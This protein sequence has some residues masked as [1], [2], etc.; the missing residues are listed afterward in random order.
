MKNKLN[1]ALRAVP[2]YVWV[3]LFTVIPLFMIVFYAFF[4]YQEGGGYEF[5]MEFIQKS[6]TNSDYIHSFLISVKYAAVSTVV[7]L[8]VGYPVA[9]FLNQINEKIRDF[10]M[11][12]FLLPMWMNFII[13]TYAMRSLME[14]NG[15]LGFL[16]NFLGIKG[17]SLI[18]TEAA[19]IIGMV[20]NFLPFMILPIYTSLTKMDKGLIEAA[21]DLGAGKIKVFTKVL[22][23][24]TMPGIVSGITMV[25]MPSVTT[26]VIPQMLNNKVMTI[27][28]I[29]EYKFKQEASSTAVSGVGAALSMVLMIIVIISMTFVNRFSDAEEI[30]EE[31]EKRRVN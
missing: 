10:I 12:L 2:L 21:Q 29:I 22:L 19:I 5:T 1:K 24:L 18:G 8:V 25:F 6:I 23:P 13:R 14:K 26:F 7:C 3:I 17:G 20:Y 11:V 28:S 15:L 9:Y 16:W 4:K 30:R 27:G 31:K